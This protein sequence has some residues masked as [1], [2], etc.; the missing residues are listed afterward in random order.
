MP[1]V[2]SAASLEYNNRI[3]HLA[4]R[5]S[6]A[7]TVGVPTTISGLPDKWQFFVPDGGLR[8]VFSYEQGSDVW[9]T[10]W[11]PLTEDFHQQP[12]GKVL[13]FAKHYAATEFYHLSAGAGGRRTTFEGLADHWHVFAHGYHWIAA[14][15]AYGSTGY[16]LVLV[17]FTV[18]ADGLPHTVH[19]GLLYSPQS[20][21]DYHQTAEGAREKLST[22]DLFLT[23]TPTGVAVGVYH[24]PETAKPG[25]P[26][27][28]MGTEIF[29]VEL[30]S[31]ETDL[32]SIRQWNVTRR[33]V[34]STD[35]SGAF[36]H[37]N[38]SSCTLSELEGAPYFR[39]LAAGEIVVNEPSELT[40]IVCDGSWDK[41]TEQLRISLPDTNVSMAMAAVVPG[42]T[43][44]PPWNPG[45]GEREAIIY[46]QVH[47]LAKVGDGRQDFGD[48]F[49]WLRPAGLTGQ[50]ESGRPE[51][52][53]TVLY[54]GFGNRP[55]IAW[56]KEHLLVSYEHGRLEGNNIVSDGRVV[57]FPVRY[58]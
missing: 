38:G 26:V 18:D 52:T 57:V 2:R 54:L 55:H 10:R 46:K 25:E 6:L 45:W 5:R 31:L 24:R 49:L 8:P 1:D 28:G 44:L 34:V 17:Q 11:D 36:Q 4:P 35:D 12:K 14:S 51:H 33:S 3:G 15:L 22:N 7:F 13:E 27:A 50:G 39:L 43:A 56:W 30:A 40:L 21:D 23:P 19:R 29:Q 9:A 41:V 48:I 37:A 20:E 42:P 58:W 53:G 16:G 47:P 32:G